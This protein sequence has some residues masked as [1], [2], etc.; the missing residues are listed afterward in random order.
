[1]PAKKTIIDSADVSR[2]IVSLTFEVDVM[3]NI[4]EA[5]A[6]VRTT[7]KSISSDGE[8]EDVK[9]KLEINA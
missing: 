9:I 7:L 4:E 1:M 3:D 2:I 5:M 6:N 8:I